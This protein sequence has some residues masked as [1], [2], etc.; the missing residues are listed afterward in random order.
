MGR[1]NENQSCAGKGAWQAWMDENGDGGDRVA[2]L[3]RGNLV[4]SR[5]SRR[6]A[7]NNRKGGERRFR[8]SVTVTGKQPGLT[9]RGVLEATRQPTQ[10]SSPAFINA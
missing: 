5:W 2:R 6:Q 9:Q 10:F 7:T 8:V 3:A 4:L 1:A